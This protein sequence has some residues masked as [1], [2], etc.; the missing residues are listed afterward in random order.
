MPVQAADGPVTRPRGK[1]LVFLVPAG[2]IVVNRCPA[3]SRSAY[4]AGISH[5][6][7]VN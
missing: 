7:D 4:G 1:V 2:K 5:S 6:P 3:I